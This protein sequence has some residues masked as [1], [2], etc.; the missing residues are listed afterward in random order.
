MLRHFG[1][2]ARIGLVV[3]ASVL[4]G[5]TATIWFGASQANS[6]ALANFDTA[7]S[8]TT[9]L[10]ADSLAAS[11]RFARKEAIEGGWSKLTRD[12]A[13]AL[14]GIAALDAKG[15]AIA[16]W[17][18][19]N[20]ADPFASINVVPGRDPAVRR[21]PH[22]TVVQMPV[23]QASGG[24]PVG[25][26]LTAWS[27]RDTELSIRSAV[28]AQVEISAGVM[29]GLVTLLTLALRVVVIRPLAEMAQAMQRAVDGDMDGPTP[30]ASRT[31]ELGVL[32]RA[33][34][35]FKQVA[36]ESQHLEA[37]KAEQQRRAEAERQASLL[38]LA[39]QIEAG[40]TTALAS[41]RQ[42]VDALASNANE[43]DGVAHRADGSASATAGAAQ[44]IRASAQSVASAA[45]QLTAAVNEI[46]G[47]VAQS[48]GAVQGAVDAGSDARRSMEGLSE[49]MAKV[50]N[51]ASIIREIASRTNLL[52]LNAT[53]EAA[54][55]GD[56][57]KG[58]AVVAGEVKQ[59]A[60]Q[61]ARSTE[62]I[63]S[64]I[65]LIRTA[66]EGSSAAVAR[67]ERTVFDLSEIANSISAAVEQQGVATAEIPAA[68][69][70]PPPAWMR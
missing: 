14:I 40:A 55:A 43:L 1:V 63:G 11:V 62:E 46:A 67:I 69:M 45:E 47:Q 15:Q 54:R 24:E 5:L 48:A 38:R 13:T 10:L 57:G 68:L 31:D 18:E 39:G 64:L 26:L 23:I 41:I 32:A 36:L 8:Q 28:I 16:A 21:L 56:A 34:A 70:P 33:L 50:G 19:S 35:R 2:G 37:D 12:P 6:V 53:I 59:L 4:V 66:S 30:S 9:A 65:E 29:V 17:H 42:R 61:T 60:A 44:D 51:V 20:A 7:S 52:A 58:F 27:H 49:Q 25:T 3:A 22:A